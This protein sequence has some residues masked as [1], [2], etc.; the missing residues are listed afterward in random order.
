[1][2]LRYKQTSG[3]EEITASEPYK[4]LTEGL[5]EKAGR[6][7]HG[8]I[9][10]RRRGGGHKRLYRIVD[11]RRDRAG[12]PA[13]V[14]TIEYDPNRSARIAL[15]RYVDGQRRYII[16]A[17]GLQV[18]ATIVNSENAALEAGNVLPLGKLPMNTFVY[19][20][21]LKPGKGA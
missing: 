6:N 21:E 17:E 1:K 16:A 5:R 7:N 2:T 10:M 20:V 13:V 11:F 9:T 14:E 15:I 19:N 3:F 8:K 12:V 4:P 18:G